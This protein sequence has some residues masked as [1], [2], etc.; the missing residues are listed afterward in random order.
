MADRTTGGISGSGGKNVDKVYKPMS[1]A[2]TARN[3]KAI[4]EI[5]KQ[6][7]AKAPTAEELAK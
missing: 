1:E 3:L 5:R 7:G 4:E 6:L 2:Q